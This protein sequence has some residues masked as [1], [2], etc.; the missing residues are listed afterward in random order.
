[1]NSSQAVSYYTQLTPFLTNLNNSLN[2]WLPFVVLMPGWV[3]NL[4][5][6]SVFMRKKFW[7]NTS[8]MGYYY[9]L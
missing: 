2:Y 3:L 5:T 9:S 8:S 1:M 6:A 7:K 4:F